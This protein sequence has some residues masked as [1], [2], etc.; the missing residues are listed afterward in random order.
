MIVKCCKKVKYNFR[1]LY[2]NEVFTDDL[3]KHDALSKQSHFIIT[4]FLMYKIKPFNEGSAHTQVHTA[5]R[6]SVLFIT[7][8]YILEYVPREFT[9][10]GQ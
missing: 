6:T 8:R 10:S 3:L 2:L 5:V 9:R 1:F 4:D 7:N